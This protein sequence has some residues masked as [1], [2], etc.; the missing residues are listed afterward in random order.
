MKT[1]KSKPSASDCL[2]NKRNKLAKSGS[3]DVANLDAQIV[4]TIMKE[5]N[6]KAQQFK[7]Y[8]NM[9]GT[10][11]LHKMWQLKRSYGPIRRHHFP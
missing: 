11:S 10:I 4:Q 2:I 1:N 9:T 6:N 8:C 3:K 5:E 7:K